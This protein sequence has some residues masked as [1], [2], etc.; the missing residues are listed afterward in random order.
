MLRKRKLERIE[1]WKRLAR[2]QGST[3]TGGPRLLGTQ[4]HFGDSGEEAVSPIIVS[5]AHDCGSVTFWLSSL[6]IIKS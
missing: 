4:S 6:P 5:S 1:R 2:G 3:A